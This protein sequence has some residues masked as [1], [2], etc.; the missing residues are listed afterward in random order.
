MAVVHIFNP[1]TDFALGHDKDFYT[2]PKHVVRF[3]ERLALLPALF[4]LP[5][6][7]ILIPDNIER[8]TAELPFFDITKIKNLSLVS[9]N[10]LK[11]NSDLTSLREASDYR[12]WGW[13]K[14]LR[15]RLLEAGV[16]KGLL[17]DNERLK[18]LREL[19]HRCSTVSFFKE[20]A[21]LTS[22]IL[23]PQCLHS[24]EEAAEFLNKHRPICFKAPWS[25]SGRG[26]AF[27]D[28]MSD[29]KI[30][31]WAHGVIRSQN[32]VMAEQALNRKIDFAS[33]WMI[34]NKTIEFCGFSL[35]K[36]SGRGKYQGN[37]LMSQDL[38]ESQIFCLPGWSKEILDAQRQFLVKHVAPSYSG[39][40]GIDM[41]ATTETINPF[42]EMNLRNTMGHISISLTKTLGSPDNNFLSQLLKKYFPSGTFNPNLI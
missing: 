14:D 9:Y 2:P 29:E 25:S 41:F 19:S 21:S 26:I 30:L 24:L 32:T 22:S 11:N 10:E 31:E 34:E 27:S 8:K 3:R 36:S 1:E 28:N 37:F 5:H 42:V 17:P 13:N 6:E 16:E 4:A 33:E 23:P 39:P 18:K 35:F 7:Y 38:I 20:N 15:R 12:P 40:V